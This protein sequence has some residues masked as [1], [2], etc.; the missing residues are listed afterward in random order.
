M[1]DLSLF[2]GPAFPQDLQGRRGD[3]PSLQGMSLRDYFAAK[4]L[5]GLIACP[6]TGGS[7]TKESEIAKAFAK[8]SYMYADEMLKA[9]SE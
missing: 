8:L 1:S 6:S 3:D 9:R 5:N 2:N 4:A 7:L